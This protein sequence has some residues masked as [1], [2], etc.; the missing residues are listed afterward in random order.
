MGKPAHHDYE[1][2]HSNPDGS[3][4]RI[5]RRFL[6]DKHNGE[7]PVQFKIVIKSIDYVTGDPGDRAFLLGLEL[8]SPSVTS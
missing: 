1:V 2:W 3:D 8:C 7:P 5:I 6:S 4:R